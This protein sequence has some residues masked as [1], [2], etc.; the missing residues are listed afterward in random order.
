M[1]DAGEVGE[2]YFK[3]SKRQYRE[4]TYLIRFE[5][6]PDKPVFDLWANWPACVKEKCIVSY[7]CSYIDNGMYCHV[8]RNRISKLL[9]SIEDGFRDNPLSV[10]KLSR[11][12]AEL[13][14]LYSQLIRAQMYD[15]E[16]TN[17]V[18]DPSREKP[19]FTWTYT[20]VQKLIDKISKSW[21]DIGI[22][23]PTM[24][25]SAPAAGEP[26]N[27]SSVQMDES[28]SH[29]QRMQLLSSQAKQED[30]DE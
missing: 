16:L 13:M 8:I 14:P 27:A 10:E 17:M 9:M 11:I 26:G 2:R 28:L 21:K 23:A 12:G 1:R 29:Y 15:D 24:K 3:R 4:G 30:G 7:R 22:Y 5:S 18:K 19:Q 25:P 20:E 6:W